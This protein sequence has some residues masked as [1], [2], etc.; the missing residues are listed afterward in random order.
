M[1]NFLQFLFRELV[2]LP[3]WWCSW[4]MCTTSSLWH[5]PSFTSLTLSTTSQTASHGAP[6]NKD[7]SKQEVKNFLTWDD[8]LVKALQRVPQILRLYLSK[9]IRGLYK[10]SF[11]MKSTS[12]DW[13]L[14]LNFLQL[15]PGP[16]RTASTPPPEYSRTRRLRGLDTQKSTPQPQLSFTGSKFLSV[17]FSKLQPYPKLANAAHLNMLE[18][19]FAWS[20][21]CLLLL[22]ELHTNW[23]HLGNWC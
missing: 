6:A 21:F 19:S 10:Q 18:F 11:W 2:T 15:G 17:L 14:V 23:K 7:V 9:F 20:Y 5:G 4:R 12:S 3:W 16:Q 22:K 8:I 1:L 13:Q